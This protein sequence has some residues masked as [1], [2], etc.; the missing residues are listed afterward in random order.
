MKSETVMSPLISFLFF[1]IAFTIWDLLWF[2]INFR[3]F[4]SHVKVAIG[5]L[6]G[7]V[8]NLFMALGCMELLTIL[9]FQ[10]LS[11]EYYFIYFELPSIYF[12]NVLWRFSVQK[13]F[14]TSVKFISKYFILFDGII[15]GIFSASDN[16]L[17]S[18]RYVSNFVC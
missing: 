2:H 10:Y 5:L 17:S 15:D 7:I 18:Y 6:I 16:S 3:I 12:I 14:I 11:M 8:L 4:F 9:I 13:F 1:R